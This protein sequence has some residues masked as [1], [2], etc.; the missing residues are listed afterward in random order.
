MEMKSIPEL[1]DQIATS[2]NKGVTVTISS[3]RCRFLANRFLTGITQSSHEAV[4]LLLQ[5]WIYQ[6]SLP[7]AE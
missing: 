7:I 2:T 5:F 6:D 1:S 3:L 4:S